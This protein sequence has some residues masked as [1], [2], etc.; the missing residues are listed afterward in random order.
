MRGKGE[1]GD[2]M[3]G[4]HTK[5]TSPEEREAFIRAG[6]TVLNTPLEE[7][8][9][10]S[11]LEYAYSVI[12]SRALPDARDGLKP[13]HRRILYTMYGD[14]LTPDHAHVKSARVV[15][16]CLGRYHPHG[17][18]SVYE[19]MVRLAQ[20]FSLNTPLVDGHGNF[21]SPNDSAA[22]ARYT[23]ARMSKNA[24]FM[25]EELKE[26]AVDFVPNYDGSLEEPS[27]LPAAFPNLI[28]NGTSGIAVGMATNMIPHNANEAIMAARLLLRKP[29]VSLD[30]L[31]EI[32]PGPDLPTGGILVGM[33][34]V[35]NAYE[36]G[37]GTVRIRGK[38]TVEPLEGSRGR[39]SIVITELPYQV[40]TEKIIEALKN[41][42]SKKRL[43]GISDVKDLSDRRHGTRL[44]VE[45]KTGVNP[46]AL[47]AEL[48]KYTPL[49]TSFGI[50]NLTLVEGK[51]ETLGLKRLLEVFIQHRVDVVTRRT[52]HRLDKAEARQHIVEGL[53]IALANIEEVVRIIR[54]SADTATAKTTLMRKFKLS[55]IQTQNILDM[56]LRRLVNLEVETLKKEHAELAERI[57]GLKEI[58][59]NEKVLHKTIDTE[60]AEVQKSMSVERKTTLM[61]GDL[62]EV[63]AATAPASTV[64]VKD[65]KCYVFLSSTGM[66]IRS[67]GGS[68]DTSHA[69]TARRTNHAHETIVGIAPV[70]TRAQFIA[71][72]NL[73]RAFRVNA[74][75]IPAFPA[76]VKQVSASGGI[77]AKELVPLTS[78]ERLITV[79]PAVS[80]E[81]SPRGIALGTKHGVVKICQPDW[82]LRTDEFNIMSLKNGDEIVGGGWC[83]DGDELVFISETSNLLRY[84]ATSVRPQGRSGGGM[85]GMKLPAKTEILSFN[86]VPAESLNTAQV[87]THTG[88]SAKTT[89]FS[90]YP[91]KGRG[92][93]GVR[94]HKFL[95]GETQL[96]RT[97]VGESITAV[98]EDGKELKTDGLAGRRDGSGHPFAPA[99]HVGQR[100]REW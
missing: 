92:T 48:Y 62:K 94:S 49:E 57:K 28:V 44:V 3:K 10:K 99:S 27:V 36:T 83:R 13:V 38:A 47:L 90:E 63:L 8:I 23:E 76:K 4:Q 74:M 59:E 78:G 33:D 51:P 82:P 98:G 81:E 93:G 7:E 40:G 61:G 45:C 21:G 14:G 77:P 2:C 58:L 1:A 67:P 26:D 35:R 85:A 56:P 96:V 41:E 54:K 60:L 22:A 15:G 89:F 70:T 12:H 50:N 25:V 55:D 34:E 19:A 95:K 37:R 42:V 79:V 100:P 65:E 20:D 46:T 72:T 69:K 71:V 64:E 86:V 11:Y 30:E 80:E 53:L 88:T 68:E 66:L 32:I 73:G 43:Q 9:S 5:N 16:S 39:N 91:P 75:E 18:S 29:S 52:Q 31:M 17:D 24:I 6:K 84:P 97:Y 87:F